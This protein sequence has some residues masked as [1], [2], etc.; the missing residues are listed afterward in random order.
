MIVEGKRN[1]HRGFALA[2]G[3]APELRSV[4]PMRRPQRPHLHIDD[5]SLALMG[6]VVVG[7]PTAVGF[8]IWQADEWA[9]SS[10]LLVI[11]AVLLLGGLFG[12]FAGMVLGGLIVVALEQ[13]WEEWLG[14]TLPG[15]DPLGTAWWFFGPGVAV[16][17][18]LGWAAAVIQ[19]S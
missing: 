6:A 19:S 18:A 4:F 7:L 2:H 15:G 8:A 9:T 14:R 3:P 1:V 13:V 5:V 17:V 12:F 10:P 16:G 11:P